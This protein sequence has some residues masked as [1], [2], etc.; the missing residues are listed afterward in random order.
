MLGH[1][2]GRLVTPIK[3]SPANAAD[4]KRGLACAA[5]TK[6]H[7]P[8]AFIHPHNLYPDSRPHIIQA[9]HC[10]EYPRSIATTRSIISTITPHLHC[11]TSPL[12]LPTF[13]RHESLC[14][15]VCRAGQ[16]SS[17][18]QTLVT[19]CTCA[20]VHACHPHTSLTPVCS[21][22]PGVALPHRLQQ[23][24]RAL[25]QQAGR[26]VHAARSANR[27]PATQHH[28]AGGRTGRTSEAG[29]PVAYGWLSAPAAS[30]PCT[31]RG[32]RP[33]PHGCSEL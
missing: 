3:A 16:D 10:N 12:P 13:Q 15:S 8:E 19:D 29:P 21:T 5:D 4:T 23:S 14:L 11:C 1:L 18:S 24:R 20:N 30:P 26:R 6:R 7:S 27:P 25:V 33:G 2:F 31:T 28:A 17:L 32:G 22:T 9:Q